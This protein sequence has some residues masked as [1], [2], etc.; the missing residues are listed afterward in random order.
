MARTGRAG[1]AASGVIIAVECSGPRCP[2]QA[3]PAR[4]PA[5]GG[6][7]AR[8]GAV[9]GF[10]LA[11][12]DRAFHW[13]EGEVEGPDAVV[14]NCRAVPDPRWVRYAWADN[15]VCNLYGGTGL[16]ASPFETAVPGGTWMSCE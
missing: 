10:A 12:A 5:A 3:F 11:G 9:K 14:L 4:F 15:P 13:A 7:T 8:G 2:A 16:P 1:L 6:L